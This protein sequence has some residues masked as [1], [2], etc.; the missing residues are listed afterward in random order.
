LSRAATA[1][2]K[3]ENESCTPRQNRHMPRTSP[4]RQ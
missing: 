4:W 2:A 3:S 1:S